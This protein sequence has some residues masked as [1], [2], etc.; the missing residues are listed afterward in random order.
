MTPVDVHD[1]A[2]SAFSISI[3]RDLGKV[4]EDGQRISGRA[5]FALSSIRESIIEIDDRP[6]FTLPNDLI[7][8]KS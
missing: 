1:F 8:L 6:S 5:T 2:G 4:E 3:G 7:R